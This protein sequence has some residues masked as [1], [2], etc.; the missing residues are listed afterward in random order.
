MTAMTSTVV[1]CGQP[2]PYADSVYVFDITADPSAT[3]AQVWEY[4]QTLRSAR[5]R[6]DNQR[7]DGSC[8]FPFGLQSYG[9]LRNPAVGKW[10]YSVTEPYCD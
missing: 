2:R 1:Q 5:N 10:R 4:G 9:S 6:D 7:H 3:E 8:G